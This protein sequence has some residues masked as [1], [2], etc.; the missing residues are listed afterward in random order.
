MFDLATRRKINRGFSDG[1][2]RAVEIVVTPVLLGF[3]GALVDGWLGTR[4][5]FTLGLATFGVCGIF[6]KLWLGYDREMKLEEAK[7]PGA[8]PKPTGGTP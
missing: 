5:G 1:F 6:A 8:R 7:V 3:A 4:P 2:T